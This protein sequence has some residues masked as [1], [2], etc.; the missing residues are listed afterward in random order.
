MRR[1]WQLL[2]V[3]F[4]SIL[5]LALAA[6]QFMNGTS[7]EMAVSVLAIIGGLGLLFTGRWGLVVTCLALLLAI[8]VYFWQMWY[9]PIIEEDIALVWPNAWKMLVAL[10]L[11][12]Y[13]GRERIDHRMAS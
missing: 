11:F 1:L 6:W 12:I 2:D 5:L 3:F 13:I 9:Q 7:G 8:G 10:V 4:F